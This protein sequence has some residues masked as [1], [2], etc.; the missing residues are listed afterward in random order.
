VVTC[1]AYWKL[2]DLFVLFETLL[3]INIF[4]LFHLSLL[5]TVLKDGKC[6]ME[7]KYHPSG[8]EPTSSELTIVVRTNC[9]YIFAI[10]QGLRKCLKEPRQMS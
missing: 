7:Y 4:A 6:K 2:D 9:F 8:F 10:Y 5:R 1:V 3:K